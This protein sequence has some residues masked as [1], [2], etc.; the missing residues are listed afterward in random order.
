MNLDTYEK[1]LIEKDHK[2][3]AVHIVIKLQFPI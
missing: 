2:K 3:K 1:W